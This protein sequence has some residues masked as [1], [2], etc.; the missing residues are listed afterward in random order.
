M[1]RFKSPGIQNRF[2]IFIGIVAVSG[3][4]IILLFVFSV[5]RIN[6]INEF[7]QNIFQLTIE[8]QKM[9]LTEQNFLLHYTEDQSFF[10]SGNNKYLKS[11]EESAKIISD[12]VTQLSENPVSEKVGI[13]NNLEKIKSI[14]QGYRN[15]FKDLANQI[16][17]KG[18]KTTG[19]I[20]ELNTNAESVLK[21]SPSEKFT[22]TIN[23]LNLNLKDYLIYKDIKFASAFTTSF[24][25]LSYLIDG[26]VI[27]NS[28]MPQTDS[29]L[30][31]SNQSINIQ[32]IEQ[33]NLYKTNFLALLKIDQ[34]I[35][36][37]TDQGLLKDLKTE[38]AKFEPEISSILSATKNGSGIYSGNAWIFISITSLLVFLLL[39]FTY[40][41]SRY[42]SVPLKRLNDYL[43]PLSKGILPDKIMDFK[44]NN[45]FQSMTNSINELI[46]GLKKTTGFAEA[47]GRGTFETNFEPLSSQDALGNSLLEMRK[48]LIKAQEEEKKR[49]HE[50]NLRKWANEGLAEFN[51]IL[52]Q[53][54]GD[55]DALTSSIVRNI[56]KFLKANQ[57]GLFL[58]NDS[59]KEDIHL[60]L[61]ATYAYDQERKKHKKIYIG[62]GLVGMCAVEKSTVYLEEIP[63]GYLSI[64][65]GLGGSSPR[66]LLIVP[67]KLE[68]EIFGVLEIA[69]FNKFKPHEIEFVE[70]VTES[71]SSTLSLAK[72]NARTA[73]L[74]EKSQRQAE[75]MAAQEEEMRQNLEELQA[76]QEESA[77]REAEMSSILKAINNSSLVVEFDL[78]G[79]IINAN[80]AFLDLL[81]LE[82][83]DLLG[84]HQG[85]FEKMDE[86]NIRS[87]EFWERLRRGDII[88]EIHKINVN[89]KFH[90]L[91]EVYTPILNSEGEPYKILNLATD[92]T[93]SKKLEQEL[94]S[95]AEEMALQE[96]E[97]RKNLLELEVTQKEMHT[98]QEELRNAN[99]KIKANE[100]SLQESIEAAK[101]HERRLKARNAELAEREVN[102][103]K[104]VSEL[105]NNAKKLKIENED[106]E[107]ANS[108]MIANEKL[109]KK[110]LKESKD[111]QK[112]MEEQ[113]LL[114]QEKENNLVEEI[115]SLNNELKKLK[116]K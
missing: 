77:R 54:A 84:R 92:I 79:Y 72:I 45:E 18:S 31:S 88:S 38:S 4:A 19:K 37:N 65:S 56:V 64:S 81:G 50:D 10:K 43:F 7:D 26:K 29:L 69:S 23:E 6:K 97:L 96:E 34:R 9:L 60:E 80:Q 30:I 110:F 28:P 87:E 15:V 98:K 52:R 101:E 95:K 90:W 75:E 21:L 55:I 108:K 74:L 36:L 62:E 2:R 17:L 91:H 5:N 16:Y 114:M 111:Q 25:Q 116:G 94:L 70:R 67:L 12:L 99:D 106:Y 102:Y 41:L 20:G 104:T 32:L 44:Q 24:N 48:N 93:E 78:N 68:E 3:L 89:N 105:E 73:D 115:N 66:S 13:I 47:I 22:S 113:I 85:D 100:L 109:L 82:P 107:R 33:L 40:T 27:T 71:I 46:D 83:K 11:H 86:V 76:T 51:E 57:S 35:G 58:I 8:Q 1:S 63:Q 49:Q 42:L 103:I 61:V 39:A 14:T 59:K 53:A 112:K